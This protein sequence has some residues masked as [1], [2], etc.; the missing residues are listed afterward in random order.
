[1]KAA[2]LGLPVAGLPGLSG[3]PSLAAAGAP[4]N[5]TL[6]AALAG[7]RGVRPQRIDRGLDGSFLDRLFGRR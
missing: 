2:H 5:V 3:G 7:D 6:P 1:M 4:A